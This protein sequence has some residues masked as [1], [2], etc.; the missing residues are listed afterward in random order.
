[1]RLS[2]VLLLLLLLQVLSTPASG[3]KLLPVKQSSL[4]GAQ[5]PTTNTTGK[6]GCRRS[7]CP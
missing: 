1:V 5:Q 6:L 7:S 3:F 2:H 4:P